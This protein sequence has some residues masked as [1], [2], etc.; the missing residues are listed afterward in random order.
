MESRNAFHPSNLFPLNS[1]ESE[2]AEQRYQGREAQTKGKVN[3]SLKQCHRTALGLFFFRLPS[4]GGKS[5]DGRGRGNGDRVGSSYAERG[6][7]RG[8]L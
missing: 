1:S 7:R 4:S 2:R 3:Y 6:I 5:G 8:F